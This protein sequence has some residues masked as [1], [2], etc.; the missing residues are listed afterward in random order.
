MESEGCRLSRLVERVARGDEEAFGFFYDIASPH[1]FALASRI[2]KDR[3]LAEEAT[4]DVFVQVWQR[5]GDFEPRRGNVWTWLTLLARTRA[6][7]RQRSHGRQR[8]FEAEFEFA[9]ASGAVDQ[10]GLVA[11]LTRALSS[12]PPEERDPIELSYF[13]GLSYKESAQRLQLPEGT[14][15]SRIRNGLETLRQILR[16][17][18]EDTP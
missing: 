13:G 15:K 16:G 8:G 7:D 5:A 18:Y 6:V 11:D 4:L 2:L 9:V 17:A 12:L 1:V 3:H 14:V 10:P